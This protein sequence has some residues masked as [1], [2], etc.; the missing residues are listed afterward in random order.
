MYLCYRCTFTKMKDAKRA[1]GLEA[2]VLCI[3]RFLQEKP[4]CCREHRNGNLK[5]RVRFVLCLALTEAAFA[6][7][8]QRKLFF[9]RLP[10]TIG[11][12][13]VVIR[14]YKGFYII[15]NTHTF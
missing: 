11:E 6:E 2:V 5:K 1:L 10:N 8:V 14:I 4:K 13:T 15:T 7:F 3:M 12:L 9:W